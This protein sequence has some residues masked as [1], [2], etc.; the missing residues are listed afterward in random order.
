[1]FSRIMATKHALVPAPAVV[2]IQTLIVFLRGQKVM[3]DSDLAMLFGVETKALNRAV[4]RN[5]ERFPRDFMFQLTQNEFKLLQSQYGASKIGRGG[6]RFLPYAF[7]EHG[8]VMAA[9]VLNSP[10][11]IEASLLIVRT[12]IQ[13]RELLATHADIRRKLEELE[14]KY[15]RQFGTVFEAIHELM[16]APERRT[17]GKIGFRRKA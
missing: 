8:I 5:R 9:N 11:A 17:R 15:D 7:T 6:R 3:L 16:D 13:M 14:K 2:R 12:F 10:R 4:A 1:M